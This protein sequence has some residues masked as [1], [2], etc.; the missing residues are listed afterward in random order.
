MHQNC[1]SLEALQTKGLG[2]DD[3]KA[4]RQ[5]CL[6]DPEKR[7]Q[8]A[9]GTKFKREDIQALLYTRSN[10]LSRA[11]SGQNRGECGGREW[12]GR[13]SGWRSGEDG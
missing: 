12:R 2:A 9:D 8:D 11:N 1:A 4:H 13:E 5:E 3:E 7:R 10:S 6:C